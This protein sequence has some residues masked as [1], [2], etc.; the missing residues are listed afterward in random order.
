MVAEN[1]WAVGQLVDTVSHSPIWP[2]TAIFIIED[3]A[4]NG[5]DHVNAHRMPA[6]VISPYARRG[7][8]VST[9]YDTA[10]VL[11]SMELILGLAPL[12]LNDALAVP[13]HDAFQAT[14][15]NAEPYTAV[16]PDYDLLETN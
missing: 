13:M 1:D 10:S 3:D 16:A 7:A 9:R 11:R 14:P 15:D 12:G 8:V 6:L 5:A 2:H 4:Q